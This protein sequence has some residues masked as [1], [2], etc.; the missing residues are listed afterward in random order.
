MTPCNACRGLYTHRP[1]LPLLAPQLLEGAAQL[2][3]LI[4][5]YESALHEEE[6]EDEATAAGE[7]VG[8][9][10]CCCRCYCG[11]GWSQAVSHDAQCPAIS[12][13]LPSCV[14]LQ[15]EP[16]EAAAPTPVTPG[17]G[18]ASDFRAV[19]A[20]VADPLVEMCER[21]SEALNPNA[22]SR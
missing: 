12:H 19:L 7:Q 20:A 17:G 4:E 10:L 5:C 2:T 6:E 21:A 18:A 15:L 9:V 22:A 16:G 14:C 3:E 8:P 13:A 1:L 11:S